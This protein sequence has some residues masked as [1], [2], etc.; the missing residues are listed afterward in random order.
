MKVL[1]HTH[2][3]CYLGTT[4]SVM[5]YARY[6]QEVL[7]NESIICYN[8]DFKGE[9]INGNLDKDVLK[10][11][12]DICEVRSTTD[13]NYNDVCKDVDVAYF[14]RSGEPE[15]LPNT[16]RTAIHAVF[17]LNTP[18]GDRYAYISEWLSKKVTGGVAPW[19]PYIVQMP[20]PNQ[21]MREFF[22]IPKDK[23]IIGRLGSWNIFV[24]GMEWACQAI[25][26]IVNKRNDIVFL[27]VNTKKFYEHPNII[28]VN[29]IADEQIKSN[30]INTCDAMIHSR[31]QEESFGM[32]ICEFLFHNKPVLSWN[33]GVDQHHIDLLKDTGLLYN[34][35]ADLE[36]K[37][38]NIKS[39]N[40]DYHKIVEKFNPN[41]VMQQFKSVF[42]D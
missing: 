31:W 1:F 42:L 29:G 6:N 15:P 23:I 11:W 5:N 25:V 20:K 39:F 24:D 16:A 7:G 13:G 19:V 30:F 35:T 21:D 41:N 4:V 3:P 27:L 10:K 12:T 22:G 2:T 26:N 40:G 33:G 14:Q 38:D 17:Q 9:M 28:Y 34:S 18:H 37:L 8:H 32:A 36:N